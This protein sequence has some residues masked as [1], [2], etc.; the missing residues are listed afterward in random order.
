MKIEMALD[1]KRFPTPVLYPLSM[2][3]PIA[4]DAISTERA[5]ISPAKVCFSFKKIILK[6]AFFLVHRPSLP[7][8]G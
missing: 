3:F 8:S 2:C 7:P 6:S 4:G 1:R 5:S